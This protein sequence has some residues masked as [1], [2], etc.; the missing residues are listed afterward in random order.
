[1]FEKVSPES[2]GVS[3]ENVL[4]FIKILEDCRAHTHSLFM[5]RGNKVFLESYYKP[6]DGNFLHRMYSVSKT[7][8]A[9]A[10]G[11]AVTEGLV[12]LDDVIV[13]Y[14][15]EFRNE[16]TDEYHDECTIG[17]M[18]RMKSNIGSPIFWWGKYK[19]RV[20]AYY[21][22]K[23]NKV[24]GTI[25]E[26][27]SIGSFLLG[28]IIEKLTGKPFLEY[29]KEKVLLDIGFSKESYTL[30]EPGGFTVG[31]S[32]VMCTTRDLALFARFIM[33]K[34]EW[35]G[36]Q[37]ID[38]DFMENLAK[39]QSHNDQNGTFSSFNSNG[40]GYLTWITH[41]TGFSLIGMGDQLAV[42]DTEKD[43]LFV[44]TSDNQADRSGRHVIFHE[45]ARHFIPEIK[46]VPLPENA[47]ANKKLEEY[48]SKRELICQYG[49]WDIPL[50]DKINAVKYKTENNPLGMASFSL[51]FEKTGGFLEIEMSG[52]LHRIP[53][54][55]G[56]NKLCSFSF[57][58]RPVLDMMGENEDGVFKCASSGAW[59]DENTFA[60]M[61]QVIDT[62]FGCLNINIAFKD[63][64]STM[65]LQ[66]SGQYVFEGINGYIIGKSERKI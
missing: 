29:L 59:V 35:N 8:V 53:F 11:M 14:F 40:Y 1:M 65:L 46:D 55:Y 5:A 39:K 2:V 18:L 34:G 44:I 43:F 10:I 50:A 19:S 12:S 26:Y 27:D 3:S 47:K 6:F 58:E 37:Y 15:P 17:D 66:K 4:K 21:A 64:R 20:E 63:S 38:R 57:G 24:P 22:Q 7:F 62:Y 23:T 13:D 49:N 30:K 32:G 9:V 51:N 25:F 60:I 16:N 31:D 52:K 61:L 42:C 28:C 45:V 56:K 54:D 48:A 36:K 33:Q 41:N